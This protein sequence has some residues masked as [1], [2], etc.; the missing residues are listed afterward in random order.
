MLE[1]H[2][3][4]SEAIRG[5]PM[6]DAHIRKFPVYLPPDYDH[7]RREPYPVVFLLAGWSGRSAKYLSQDSV[8][9]I[10]LDQRLDRAIEEKTIEP[11]I[12]VFPDGTSKLGCSQYVN[13]PAFGNYMDYIADEI[14]DF[15]D[16]KYHTHRSA[17]FRGT[18]GHSSGGFGAMVHGLLRPD[19]FLY[20]CSSAGDSFSELSLLPE[21][22]AALMAI[23]S[24]GGVEKFIA[25]I[26]SHPQPA[27]LGKKL[28]A[29]MVL[30]LAPCYAPNLNMPPLY[31]DLFFDL[32]TGAIIEE[33]WEKYLKWDP[34]RM[35]D[36]YS[37]GAKK[38]KF[39]H[40]ECGLQD[41][42]G[43][44]FGHRLIAEKLKKYGIPHQIDE[45]PG[46]HSGHHWR[47]VNRIKLMLS[48]MR[49]N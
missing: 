1:W 43:L 28:H 31:G 3:F 6:G 12:A 30:S 11:V 39:L 49:S 9:D 23:E 25:D 13:S 29:L 33:I 40:L 8:F 10:P 41:E 4:E 7:K 36:A 5:F 37:S 21:A 2:V 16:G 45:Y 27:S 20:V 17:Q 19:R 38:L 34:V 22:K 18:M 42:Y 14:V 15:I 26:F 35:I 47:F 32:K 24:A 46:G 48:K 44:Q